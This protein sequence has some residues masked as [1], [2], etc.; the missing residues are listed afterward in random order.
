MSASG[1][2]IQSLMSPGAVPLAPSHQE[3]AVGHSSCLQLPGSLWAAT[4]LCL[5]RYFEVRGETGMSFLFACICI[6]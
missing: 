2:S 6:K 4:A 5:V 3:R 1:I